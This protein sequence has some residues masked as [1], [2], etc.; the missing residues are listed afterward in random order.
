MPQENSS[1][2]SIQK[3][4]LV[5]AFEGILAF[6]KEKGIQATVSSTD[7]SRTVKFVGK[8][9]KECEYVCLIRGAEKPR[10]YENVVNPAT[11]HGYHG[12]D[13]SGAFAS[14]INPETIVRVFKSHFRNQI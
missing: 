5:P 1:F 9:G 13:M 3:E 12:T 6:L 14:D 10:I 4:L 11:D 2:S 7:D 8:I